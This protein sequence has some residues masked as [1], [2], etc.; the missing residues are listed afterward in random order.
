MKWFIWELTHNL[1]LYFSAN[2]YYCN[3]VTKTLGTRLKC[4]YIHVYWLGMQSVVDPLI[5][6]QVI[7]G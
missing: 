4:S 6:P 1:A 7:V 5:T 3:S 2:Y